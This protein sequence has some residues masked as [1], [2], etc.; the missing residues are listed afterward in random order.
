MSV[1]I[2]SLNLRQMD[3]FLE[4]RRAV[5]A[6]ASEMSLADNLAEILRKANEFVPSA[7]GSIL[8][9]NPLDKRRDKRQN[10]LTFVAA[11]GDKATRLIGSEILADQG[12]AGRVYATGGMYMHA[13]VAQESR[14]LWARNRGLTIGGFSRI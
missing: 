7:A 5:I 4:R 6:F 10:L 8:L 3:A 2:H 1:E 11:F 12:I 9:D 14:H 13:I